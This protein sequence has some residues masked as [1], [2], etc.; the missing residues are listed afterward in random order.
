ML[1]RWSLMWCL[2]LLA[3]IAS[4]LS[5]AAPPAQRLRPQSPRVAGWI[6]DGMARSAT[7]RALVERIEQG[8]VIVY[9][10]SQSGLRQGVS[11][12]V[13]WMSATPTARFVR[14]SVRPGLSARDT[15]AM[16]AHELQHVVEV[17]DH[18]EVRS[19]RALAN[20]YL[21]IGHSTGGGGGGRWDTVAALRTG[22]RVRIELL[23]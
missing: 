9:L 5:A 14:A 13:T 23:G 10:E 20:L 22:D 11:A 21:R 2:V 1:R 12:S 8:D 3:A 18:P 6:A 17:I 19:E 16:I 15:L 4:P 7:F